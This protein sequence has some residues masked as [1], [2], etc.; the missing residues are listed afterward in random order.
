MHKVLHTRDHIDRLDASRKEN[1]G[2]TRIVDCIDVST[3]GQEDYIKKS[4]G[5]I[6]YGSQ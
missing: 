4:K 1:K 5:K 6:N 2:L 3:E